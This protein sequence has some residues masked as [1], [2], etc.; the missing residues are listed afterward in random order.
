[1]ILCK[2]WK[3]IPEIDTTV[4]G[5]APSPLPPCTSDTLHVWLLSQ[6]QSQSCADQLREFLSVDELERAAKYRTQDV[7]NRYIVRRAAL[8]IVLSRYLGILPPAVEFT[9]GAYG[10]PVL[11]KNAIHF[12]LSHSDD[13]AILG[14]SMAHELGIDIEATRPLADMALVAQHHFSSAEQ[15]DLFALPEAQQL[16]GFYNCWTRKEAFIKADGRGLSI[17]LTAFDVTLKPDIPPRIYR[18]G[19]DHDVESKWT[20]RD[21]PVVRGYTAAVA[22]RHN[23]K[24][25]QLWLLH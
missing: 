7:C 2:N 14:I 6:K 17:P 10:K 19:A 15:T 9:Y 20:L 23:I 18:I 12:N 11:D 4:W 13:L 24:Q 1:M 8:R 3:Q 21:L 16:R 5:L 22:I 25:V